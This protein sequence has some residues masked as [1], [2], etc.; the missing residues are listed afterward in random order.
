MEDFMLVRINRG[1]NF[2]Q[3]VHLPVSQ[4]TNL[5]ILLGDIEVVDRSERQP[6][7]PAVDPATV[8][9]GVRKNLY[10]DRP[11]LVMTQGSLV[12]TFQEHPDLL[13]KGYAFGGKAR[14]V[15]SAETIAKYRAAYEAYIAD[16]NARHRARDGSRG[17]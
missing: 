3:E 10:N 6:A 2:G 11:E 5:A 7:A 16:A 8:N 12:E 1:P 4:E 14:R 17:Q 9:F 13:D 15:P